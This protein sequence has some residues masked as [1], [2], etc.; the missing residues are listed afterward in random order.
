MRRP[1]NYS[2]ADSARPKA[3]EEIALL[4]SQVDELQKLV[5]R[6]IVGEKAESSLTPLTGH[7]LRDISSS[8]FFLDQMYFTHFHY[9]LQPV[10]IPVPSDLRKALKDEFDQPLGVDQLVGQYFDTMHHW[11]P[12]ISKLRMKRILQ[13]SRDNMQADLAFLLSCM[14]L[15]LHA[16]EEGSLPEALSLYRVV[17]TCNLQ[18]EL[19]GVQSLMVIQG[20]V[21]IALYEIGHGIYP[22]GYT[23]VALCARQAISLGVHNPDSPKFLQHWSDWEEQ[24]RVWWFIV[25]LDR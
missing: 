8:L 11:M 15:L 25:M 10:S 23:T 9:S 19:A 22:A 3:E 6:H 14:K 13:R 7:A 18:L 16:P 21:L 5:K 24:I 2:L 4:R 17:K 1:C 12:I 20:G